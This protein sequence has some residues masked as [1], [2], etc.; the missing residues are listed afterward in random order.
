[1]T[2]DPQTIS[3]DEL[4]EIFWKTHNPTTT[5][6]QGADV[7]PQYRSI[8]FYHNEEQKEKAQAYKKELDQ[9]GIWDKPI[10]TEIEPY[11]AFYKAEDYHQ[12][13][14]NQNQNKNPYC[15]AVI[16]PKLE[17]FEKV[18]KDKMKTQKTP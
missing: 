11:E 3:Y 5:N 2:Y 14:Y 8:I 18:F 10:V 15:A 16:T 17:K 4:L 12:D 7:G 13:Y 6:Q 9:A 1:M